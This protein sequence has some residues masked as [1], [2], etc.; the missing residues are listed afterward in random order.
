MSKVYHIAK[1]TNDEDVPTNTTTM[2]CDLAVVYDPA[3]GTNTDPDVDFVLMEFAHPTGE[4]ITDISK[5]GCEHC[6]EL[7]LVWFDRF[8]NPPVE[9]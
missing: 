3:T 2:L 4:D 7:R 1:P 5:V 8:G 6:L 9:S